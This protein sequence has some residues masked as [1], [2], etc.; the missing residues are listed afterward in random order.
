MQFLYH[1]INLDFF[2]HI[3]YSVIVVQH[4]PSIKIL[5]TTYLHK[6]SNKI[7]LA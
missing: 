4:T 2:L 5:I 7:L 1:I 3:F 6:S